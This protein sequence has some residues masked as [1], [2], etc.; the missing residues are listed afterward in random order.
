MIPAGGF[1][2]LKIGISRGNPRLQ[3]GRT[4]NNA[5]VTSTMLKFGVWT[6]D[7]YLQAGSKRRFFGAHASYSL[8]DIGNDPSEED[9]R[10]FEDISFTLRTS[11]GTFRTSFPR[12]FGDVD[13]TAMRWLQKFYSAEA[14]LR[15]QDRAASDGL[16]SWEWAEQVFRVFPNANF[17]AS[18]VLLFL[19]RLTLPG[20]ETYIVEPSGQP[21]Q[22]I[23]PPWVVSVHHP[24]SWRYPVN[25]M[26]AARAKR[27]F[28]RLS[29]PEG[30]MESSGTAD[31]CVSKIPHIHPKALSYS[32]ANA[33]FQI[34]KRSVFEHAPVCHVLRTMNIFNRA[35]FSDDQLTAGIEA[36]F[37]SLKVGG[38][39]IVGRTLEED[40]SNHVSFLRR[41]ENKWQ[42][43]ERIGRGSEIEELALR[44]PSRGDAG[45]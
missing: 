1:R 29:L 7:R 11:N 42:A 8:L 41:G 16:S 38:F 22:Y 25:R 40:F 43:L 36:A 3:L 15:V 5:G 28:E 2:A 20:G 21:L 44:A 10:A 39:W 32:K 23:R 31:Y 9:I 33:R 14:E 24:E 34:R 6:R 4:A 19:I 17:E 12:R 30:W 45:R 26:I 18:D 35:Y 13:A 37:D 27:G